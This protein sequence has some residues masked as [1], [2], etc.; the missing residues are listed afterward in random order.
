MSSYV[1]MILV[2]ENK[3]LINENLSSLTVTHTENS[4]SIFKGQHFCRG[5]QAK[6]KNVSCDCVLH[7]P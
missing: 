6:A 2:Q 1:S 3:S 7:S 4:Y 5:L